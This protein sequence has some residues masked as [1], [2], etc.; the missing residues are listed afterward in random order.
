M[1]LCHPERSAEWRVVEGPA[2]TH[3]TASNRTNSWPAT[4]HAL[5][6]SVGRGRRLGGNLRR[7]DRRQLTVAF[8]DASVDDHRVDV[9]RL[10]GFDDR[11]LDVERRRVVDHPR[12]DHDDVGALA[13]FE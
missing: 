4:L 8:E 5:P 2:A 7:V 1:S 9:G 13:G 6:D 11:V 12:V 3:A 10:D